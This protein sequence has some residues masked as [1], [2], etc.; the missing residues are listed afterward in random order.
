MSKKLVCWSRAPKS[1][2]DEVPSKE[3]SPRC[4]SRR[5]KKETRKQSMGVSERVPSK[6]DSDTIA[7]DW[8]RDHKKEGQIVGNENVVNQRETYGSTQIAP[9]QKGGVGHTNGTGLDELSRSP[10]LSSFMN[11]LEHGLNVPL[12]ATGDVSQP[13]N[14]MVLYPSLLPKDDRHDNIRENNPSLGIFKTKGRSDLEGVNMEIFHPQVI[15]PTS[16]QQE[17]QHQLHSKFHSQSQSQSYQQIQ[18][19]NHGKRGPPPRIGIKTMMQ[20]VDERAEAKEVWRENVSNI[21]QSQTHE[22]QSRITI[23]QNNPGGNGGNPASKKLSLSTFLERNPRVS[24]AKEKVFGVLES[25]DHLSDVP[26]DVDS[27]TRERYLLACQ[28]LKMTMIQKEGAL[29]D[30]EKEYI[31][32]LLDEFENENGEGT[33]VNEDRMAAIERAILHLESDNVPSSPATAVRAHK[34]RTTGGEK[35][36]KSSHHPK[37]LNSDKNPHTA[38][39]KPKNKLMETFSNPCSPLVMARMRQRQKYSSFK[40]EDGVMKNTTNLKMVENDSDDDEDRLV[41]FDG[42]SFQNSRECPFLIL[43]AEG[44]NTNPRV[45]T[46]EMMEAL[47]GFMPIETS[48]HNFWLRFSLV[49]DG[50]SLTTLLSTIRASKYTM[51]GVETD[52]GEVFGSFTGSPWRIGSKWYGT[53]EAFLWRLKRSRYTSTKNS[54]MP[55]FEREIEIY[56]CTE[57]DD[58]VQYCTEKTIAVGG[59]GWQLNSC[60]Y[61]NSD[62]GI[63]FMVDGDLV[64]GETSSCG[65]FANPRLARYTTSSSEFAIQNLEV[66]TITPCTHVENAAHMEMRN[67]VKEYGIV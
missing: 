5:T 30:I 37:S 41:R 1:A 59:G 57:D 54:R 16:K 32:S 53:S 65:T 44:N 10:D 8:W 22:D 50:G 33:V 43:G 35:T 42:W 3:K 67:L 19:P 46:P 23:T 61:S 6:R 36:Q 55:D 17:Q 34:T 28:M 27:L 25:S 24:S 52:H 31:M 12:E 58:L 56:P 15:K 49:R 2:Y 13:Q 62:Q 51:I 64:G 11:S 26:S 9:F 14:G 38:T 39:R 20:Y 47:R 18:S 63:G 66:W 60:P 40:E 21:P 7:V 48:E 4:G 45:F 29:V